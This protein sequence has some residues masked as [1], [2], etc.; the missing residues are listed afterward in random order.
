ME[1]YRQKLEVIKNRVAELGHQVDALM[2]LLCS[3]Q[4][5]G[6]S[7][8]SSNDVDNLKKFEKAVIK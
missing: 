5:E 8:V 1:T 2:G 7:I 6:L 4:R 3:M